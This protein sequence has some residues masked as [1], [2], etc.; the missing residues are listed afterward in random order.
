M[1]LDANARYSESHEWVRKEGDLFIYGITDHAQDQLSDLVYLEPPQVGDSFKKGETIGVV[2][3]VKAASDLYL[4]MGGEIVEVNQGLVDA[5]EV[6]NSDPFGEGWIVKFK[7]ADEAEFATLLSPEAY[8]KFVA[9]E[10]H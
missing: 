3:S 8:E 6:M 7:A 4:P 2:E 5:P 9:E 1:K 10:S